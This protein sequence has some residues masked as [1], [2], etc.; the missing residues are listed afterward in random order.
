MSNEVTVP[1]YKTKLGNST[2]KGILILLA[3]HSNSNGF[4]FP[5][6]D[7]IADRAELSKRQVLRVIQVFQ[8]I[9]LV[10]RKKI[11]GQ[12]YKHSFQINLSLLETDLKAKF[13]A[14]FQS[15][16]KKSVSETSVRNSPKSVS[17]TQK[18]VSETQKS[19]S[20]TLPPDPLIGRTVNEP[21]GNL[22]PKDE[23]SVE[24]VPPVDTPGEEPPSEDPPKEEFTK[25]HLFRL[26]FDKYYQFK[27]GVP[28]PWG[29]KEAG[30]LDRWMKANPTITQEQWLTILRNRAKSPV[31]HAKPLSV[32]IGVAVGWLQGPADDWG[33]A[34]KNGATN[35]NVPTGKADR[36]LEIL[37]RSINRGKR[38]S[39]ADEDGVFPPGGDGR[40]DTRKLL[41]GAKGS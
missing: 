16:Q 2:A 18:D 24:F 8:E 37:Q 15:A 13:K 41:P 29:K 40:D 12:N 23:P 38:E 9:G 1:A 5:S 39:G 32:W 14:A 30:Q 22:L 25:H 36:N 33:K 31:G 28:G 27:N 10:E 3:D 26:D 34:I 19:V 7:T 21:S 4:S 17:A 35:G 11:K 20:E 6:I